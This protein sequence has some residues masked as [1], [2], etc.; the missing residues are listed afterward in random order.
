MFIT[1]VL[2][3]TLALLVITAPA[4]AQSASGKV[5]NGLAPTSMDSFVHE[6][7]G[8]AEEIYGD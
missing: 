4:Y 6:A 5:R 1:K 3:M 7:G 8:Q 2:K